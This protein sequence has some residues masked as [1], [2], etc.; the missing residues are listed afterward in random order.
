M[1]HLTFEKGMSPSSSQTLRKAVTSRE[2]LR[3][4]GLF[5]IG[6]VGAHIVALE[7]TSFGGEGVEGGAS[8]LGQSPAA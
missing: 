1:K 5:S 8:G 6:H 4:R 3:R 7:G 2:V